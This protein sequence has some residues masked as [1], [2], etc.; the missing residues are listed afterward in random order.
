MSK[1]AID[2]FIP[3]SKSSLLLDTNILIHLFYPTMS[4]SFM[5][6][7]EKLYEKILKKKSILLLPAIQVS[8]FINRCIRFQYE[9]YKNSHEVNIPFDF[10]KDY[11][12]TDDYRNSM[13]TILS[14]VQNDI[15]SSFTVINDNFNS[16]DPNKIYI[17]GFSYDFNDALLVQIAEQTKSSIVTHDSDFANYKLSTDII[18]ANQKLLMFS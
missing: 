16:I 15:L 14:I 6:S 18:T 3:T 9:T 5:V 10:K 13:E 4:N 8:E 11:R 1:I 2:N 12:N 7:Y 17:Y